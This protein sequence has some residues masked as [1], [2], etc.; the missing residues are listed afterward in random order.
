MQWLHG[1]RKTPAG[2]PTGFSLVGVALAAV[3]IFGPILEIHCLLAL[4]LNQI[5]FFVRN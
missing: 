4:A 5:D 3:Y 2:S 1:V